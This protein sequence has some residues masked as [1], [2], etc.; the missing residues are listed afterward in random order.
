[1]KIHRDFGPGGALVMRRP[2]TPPA[3]ARR[4]P[5]RA[6]HLPPHI[7]PSSAELLRRVVRAPNARPCTLMWCVRPAVGGGDFCASC[8]LCMEACDGC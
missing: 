1:M 2:A 4:D 7:A 3:P 5:P 8:A 6:T